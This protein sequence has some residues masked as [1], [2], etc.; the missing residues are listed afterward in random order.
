M[1]RNQ[2]RNNQEFLDKFHNK[3]KVVGKEGLLQL[4]EAKRHSLCNPSIK[5]NITMSNHM[6][7]NQPKAEEDRNNSRPQ[8]PRPKAKNKENAE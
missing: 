1:E 8:S 2:P 4:L 7:D 6:T 5:Q 3:K